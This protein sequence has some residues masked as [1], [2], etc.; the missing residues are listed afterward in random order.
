MDCYRCL[1]KEYEDR[2]LM[3]TP[4]QEDEKSEPTPICSKDDMVPILC[5]DESH[6]AHLSE[7]D[8][9]LSAYTPISEVQCFH[10]EDMSDTPS[11]MDDA[12]P[13]METFHLVDD[14]DAIPIDD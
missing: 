14:E 12:A 13:V 5:E 3:S 4:C 6:L 7:S 1:N 2:V 8:G 11:S 10:L 9:E